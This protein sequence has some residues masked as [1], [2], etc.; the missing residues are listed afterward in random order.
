MYSNCAFVLEYLALR[1]ENG[2]ASNNLVESAATALFRITMNCN[3]KMSNLAPNFPFYTD[4]TVGNRH[5]ELIEILYEVSKLKTVLNV[6]EHVRTELGRVTNAISNHIELSPYNSIL[7]SIL[8]GSYARQVPLPGSDVDICIIA[9]SEPEFDRNVAKNFEANLS[10]KLNCRVHITRCYLDTA[11]DK[12]SLGRQIQVASNLFYVAGAY[13]IY[14]QFLRISDDVLS[15]ASAYDLFKALEIERNISYWN[16]VRINER[17][18]PKHGVGGSIQ[19]ELARTISRW[20]RLRDSNL[21]FCQ[22]SIGCVLGLIRKYIFIYE[23]NKTAN[24]QV[25]FR[26]FQQD[27]LHNGGLCLD[28][29]LLTEFKMLQNS[30]FR[31]LLDRAAGEYR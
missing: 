15:T 31:S 3:I 5:C 29:K 22:R 26:Y 19:Y 25:D 16:G 4:Q 2:F 18:S 28:P 11:F 1:V 7:C 6:S 8:I 24:T 12:Y 30:I 14:N 20:L 17:T 13:G 9:R 27:A 10:V 21:D 23:L